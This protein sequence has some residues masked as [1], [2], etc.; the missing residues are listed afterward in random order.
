MEISYEAGLVITLIWGVSV[1]ATVVA[2]LMLLW[3]DFR[4]KGKENKD[5]ISYTPAIIL[6]GMSTITYVVFHDFISSHWEQFW[7]VH[8]TFIIN[9]V[10]N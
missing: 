3:C 6:L 8:L 4:N 7:A 9:Q 1:L 2:I 10:W 5:K